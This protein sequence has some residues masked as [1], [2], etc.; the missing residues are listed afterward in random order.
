MLHT[1]GYRD[2][3]R[4]LTDEFRSHVDCDLQ[5]L[6]HIHLDMSLNTLEAS[7]EY[8]SDPYLKLPFCDLGVNFAPEMRQFQTSL[9][10]EC[11]WMFTL[12]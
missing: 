1:D 6:N 7:R 11:E 10:G 5:V 4:K 2:H 12:P 3:R 8:L 9:G